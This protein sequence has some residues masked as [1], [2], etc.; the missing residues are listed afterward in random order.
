MSS[1]EI[2][3]LAE[4]GGISE[5]AQWGAIWPA[6]VAYLLTL[7]VFLTCS[8]L[9]GGRCWGLNWWAHFD[10]P[11]AF[12]LFGVGLIALPAMFLLSRRQR[13]LAN[14]SGWSSYIIPTTIVIA[15]VSLFVAMRVETH[16]LGDGY[17]LLLSLADQQAYALKLREIGESF[18]HNA[19]F[20]I[21][22]ADGKADALMAY[23]II[24]MGAGVLFVVLSWSASVRYFTSN[25]DRSLFT[26]GVGTGGYALLFFGYVENYSLFA[27]AVLAFV[28][29]GLLISREEMSRWWIFL[30]WGLATTMHVLGVVLFPA[31]AW[32]LVRETRFWKRTVKLSLPTRLALSALPITLAVAVYLMLSQ[33]SLYLR[34]AVLPL[35]SGR[36][37][38]DGYTMFS[39]AHV[40]DFINL[41]LILCPGVLL[42]LLSVSWK[43]ARDSSAAAFLLISSVSAMGSVFILDPKLGMPRDW[44]LFAFAGIPVV[45]GLYYLTLE[46]WRNHR[47]ARVAAGLAIALG[48]L[49]LLPRAAAL[50]KPEVILGHAESYRLLDKGRTRNFHAF[51]QHFHE[52]TGNSLARQ[53]NLRLWDQAYEAEMLFDSGMVYFDQGDW[54]ASVRY[55]EKAVRIDPFYWNC[56]TTL[57]AS[58]RHLKEYDK[59]LEALDVSQGLNPHGAGAFSNRAAIMFDLGRLEEAEAL[60]L[61]TLELQPKHYAARSGL[62]TIYRIQ[63]RLPEWE[64]MLDSTVALPEVPAVYHLVQAEVRARNGHIDLAVESVRRAIAAG[65]DSSEVQRFLDLRP[66]VRDR[67]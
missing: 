23:R 37:T 39:P 4:P 46:E 66:Q 44:D 3:R 8:I 34:L 47:V 50:S 25:F 43:R 13:P 32:V 26:L 28:L 20:Q 18:L 33:Q 45:V 11:V 54:A 24:S 36:F 64:A 35:L 49:T 42:L 38:L 6:L 16:F 56:W 59:A 48:V 62:L 51:L 7:V 10:G 27:V 22:G 2:D 12:V 30:P 60:F 17:T 57:G 67:L 9:D 40:L 53:L 55:M 63:S 31:V 15:M 21:L 65:C 14:P 58:Y 19:V 29:I 5:K 61:E 41:I 1:S 52:E